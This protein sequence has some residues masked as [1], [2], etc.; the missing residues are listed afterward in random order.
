MPIQMGT[1]TKIKID[2]S[3]DT[4]IK[5]I[6]IE[7]EFKAVGRVACLSRTGQNRRKLAKKEQ[8]RYQMK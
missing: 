3:Y 6:K 4:S 7:S 2:C 5:D 1:K 8:I